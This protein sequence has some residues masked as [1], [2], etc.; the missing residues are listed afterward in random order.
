MKRNTRYMAAVSLGVMAAG[1]VVTIPFDAVPWVRFIRSGFEA[2]LVGGLADWFAVTALFRHPLGIPIPHTAILPNNREKVT[3]ALVATVQNE[4][5][6]KESI[7]DKMKQFSVVPK[8]LDGIEA[9]LRTEEGA[10]TIVR[11]SDFAVRSFPWDKLAPVLEREIG[12]RLDEVDLAAVA[13]GLAQYGFANDWD[14]KALDFVLDFAEDY[15][16]RESTVRQMGVMASDAI[17]RIQ[18]GGLMSFALN[19]FAGFMSEER[20]GETIRQLLQSQ[21]WELRSARNP[22]RVAISETLRAK[23]AAMLE[24]PETKEAL[25]GWKRELKERLRLSEKLNAFL[26]QTR[27]KLLAYIH[28]EAYPRDV[29]VPVL[30]Q[31]LGRL[32]ADAVQVGRIETFVQDKLADWIE[33]NHHRIGTLIEENIRKYDNE[34]LIALI[35]DKIGSDL[36][37]IRV[38]GAI[39]GFVIGLVLAGVRFLV[40]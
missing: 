34:T 13:S 11:I 18:A 6:S 25:D 22:T 24:K 31:A 30:E 29:A 14:G 8:L 10:R 28:T 16:N 17:G 21:I 27:E 9:H 12:R 1:F 3:K 23:I 19:A 33:R 35:E 39:C 4:L 36:Q 20:L 37:W 40:E 15:I 5:L 2:G 7:R 26:E 32:R 38:N